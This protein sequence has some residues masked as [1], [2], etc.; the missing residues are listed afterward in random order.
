MKRQWEGEKTI[1]LVGDVF[2]DET[3]G[4]KA[5]IAQGEVA[6]AGMVTGSSGR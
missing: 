4:V 5:V 2:G 6:L 1:P 3:Q